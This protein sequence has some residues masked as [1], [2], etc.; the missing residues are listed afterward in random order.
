MARVTQQAE[1]GS[2][3]VLAASLGLSRGSCANTDRGQTKNR[4][5]CGERAEESLNVLAAGP[6]LEHPIRQ[7]QMCSFLSFPSDGDKHWDKGFRE[8]EHKRREREPWER[9]QEIDTIRVRH[10]NRDVEK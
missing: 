6:G 9:D 5:L 4:H 3:D 8:A 1:A 2:P 7:G 10:K